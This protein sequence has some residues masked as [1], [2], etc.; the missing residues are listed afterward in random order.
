[1]SSGQFN[2]IG[3]RQ[4]LIGSFWN[5]SVLDCIYHNII[6][7]SA[8]SKFFVGAFRIDK[9]AI[10]CKIGVCETQAMSSVKIVRKQ[11]EWM[12]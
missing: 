2:R 6:R 12:R 4:N 9:K 11:W 7:V 1:M 10:G 5:Q 8:E 3:V